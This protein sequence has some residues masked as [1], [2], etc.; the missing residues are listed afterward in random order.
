MAD[1]KLIVVLK[2]LNFNKSIPAF[3]RSE[4]M[5]QIPDPD[6]DDD[7]DTTIDEY[8]STKKWAEE[9]VRRFIKSCINR[10]QELLDK[11]AATTKLTE[12]EVFVIT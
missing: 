4:P 2:D 3:L 9:R 8:P 1:I 6:A 5:P 10:G 7:G 12:D 11:D